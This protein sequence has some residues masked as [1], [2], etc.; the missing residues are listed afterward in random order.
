MN[1]LTGSWCEFQNQNAVCW[2]LYND[3]LYFGSTDGIVYKADTG[4][5][6]NGGIITFDYQ[7]AFSNF[8]AKSRKKMLQLIRSLM[9]TNG[10]PT[11]LQSMNVDFSDVDPTGTLNPTAPPSSTWDSG[12]WDSALWGGQ[13]SFYEWASVGQIGVWATPRIKGALNGISLQ[14]NSFEIKMTVGGVI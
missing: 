5:Q 10:S 6:D 4:L 13:N 12:L 2:G 9:L 8:G 11:I 1:T 7:G 3:D 14:L